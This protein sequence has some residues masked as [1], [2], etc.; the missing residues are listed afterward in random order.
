MPYKYTHYQKI[1]CQEYKSN[2]WFFFTAAKEDK[3]VSQDYF[4]QTQWKYLWMFKKGI[5]AILM[6]VYSV[7]VHY[8][9]MWPLQVSKMW[10]L[11]SIIIIVYVVFSL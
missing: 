4:F 9:N 5:K 2:R 8:T 3:Q 10:N 1:S 11:V 7:C 6:T